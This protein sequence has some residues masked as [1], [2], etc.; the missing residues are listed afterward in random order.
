MSTP[1]S[2]ASVAR[3]PLLH[4]P[5]VIDLAMQHS[6]QRIRYDLRPGYLLRNS[7]SKV[8]ITL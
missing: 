1:L 5:L 2:L 6:E 7:G 8:P 3:V 4:I